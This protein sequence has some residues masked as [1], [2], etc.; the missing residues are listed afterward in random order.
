MLLSSTVAIH[1]Y[2]KKITNALARLSS[3]I[4]S[5]L[6]AVCLSTKKDHMTRSYKPC[7][8]YILFTEVYFLLNVTIRLLVYQGKELRLV[9]PFHIFVWSH[10]ECINSIYNSSVEAQISSASL[11]IMTETSAVTVGRFLSLYKITLMSS[12]TTSASELSQ[13]KA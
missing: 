12:V 10:L 5:E 1:M 9:I 13:Q 11:V 3:F 7:D 8:T 4:A 2:M 6:N